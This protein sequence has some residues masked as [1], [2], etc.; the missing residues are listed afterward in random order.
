MSPPTRP[1]R[2]LF[3]AVIA[4]ALGAVVAC[5]DEG[6]EPHYQPAV[7][8][9]SY[10]YF[11]LPGGQEN[12]LLPLYV[13]LDVPAR[14][15]FCYSL[16]L[17]TIAE[18][19]LDDA[20][21]VQ[22]LPKEPVP[23]PP[24]RLVGDS[25][26]LLWLL[27]QSTPSIQRYDLDS[28]EVLDVDTGLAAAADLV[29]AG[30]DQHLVAGILPGVVPTLQLLDG[31]LD[32]VD[33][34]ELDDRPLNLEFIDES[35][36]VAVLLENRRVEVYD[37]ATLAFQHSYP[38][39]FVGH[40]V[41]NGFVQLDGGDFVVSDDTVLGLIPAD[42][43]SLVEV[44][45]GNENWDLITRGNELL[46][47]D[48]IGSADPNHGEVRRYDADLNR[49]GDPF[50]TGKN[51]GFGGLDTQ[52]GL[53]WMNSEGSTETWAVDPDTGEAVHKIPLG[54]HV[55]SVA[56]DPD[57]PSRVFVSGRLSDTLFSVDLVDEH[58]VHA[59][60]DFSWPVRPV[61]ADG[62]LWVLDQLNARLHTFDRDT[63]VS[64]ES[65]D[66]GLSPNPSLA[67]SDVARHDA[68][69]T[70][71]VS[72]GWDD[73]L[74]EVDPRS[75]SVTGRWELEGVPLDRDIACRLEVLVGPYAV[76]VVRTRDGRVSRLDLDSGD[77]RTA[78]PLEQLD[79]G[80]TRLQFAA[81]SEDGGL[82]YLGPFAIDPDTLGRLPELDR[83]WSFPVAQVEE[84]WIAWREDDASIVVVDRDGVEV[85]ALPTDQIGGRFSPELHYLPGWDGR[86]VFTDIYRAGIL[87]WPVK[88]DGDAPPERSAEG[89]D[90]VGRGKD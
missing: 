86:V 54:V 85:R 23:T 61:V 56:T 76:F 78:S 5:S 59:D 32:I 7:T 24:T 79:P 83:N 51:S 66:L 63:L 73:V 39:P 69:G 6:D 34:I 58:V 31:E 74:V 47:L 89:P 19:D 27:R 43:G 80:S 2:A 37:A 9:E 64:S 60:L 20:A 30:P 90:N 72:H 55:E 4:A 25:P 44:E 46:V 33:E 38:A 8:P 53:V 15:L 45:E 88:L 16:L 71:L 13:T 87:A 68:R 11:L 67:L 50:P 77:V 35:H 3:G 75:G 49:L 62:S 10:R 81:L 17:G 14:R 42:G 28:G 12:H 48:R 57:R 1:W 84:R 70:L 29:R 18:V 21:L 65:Y 41:G 26:R 52:T 40:N 36:H 22:V 82:L